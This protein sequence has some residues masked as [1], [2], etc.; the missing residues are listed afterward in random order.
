MLLAEAV[1]AWVSGV[2][3]A[4]TWVGGAFVAGAV[5]GVALWAAAMVEREW[6]AMERDRDE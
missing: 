4:A 5:L 3:W 6:R 2:I 1:V